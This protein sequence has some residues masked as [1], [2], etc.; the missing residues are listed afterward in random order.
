MTIRG[1]ESVQ[2]WVNKAK[3][4]QL[5]TEDTYSIIINYVSLIGHNEAGIFRV[6]EWNF[7]MNYSTD[8]YIRAWFC[9]MLDT[10]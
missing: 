4:E 10:V 8:C 5:Q 9:V 1:N 6:E 2:C 7:V 3:R